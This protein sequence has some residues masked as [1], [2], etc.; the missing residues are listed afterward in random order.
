MKKRIMAVILSLLLLASMSVFADSYPVWENPRQVN[1]ADCKT[2]YMEEGNPFVT[3]YAPWL[4]NFHLLSDYDIEHGVLGGEACQYVCALDISPVN[5]DVMYFG[6][7]TSGVY[8]TTTRGKHW[9]N[10]TGNAAGH[11]VWSIMCDPFDVNTVYVTMRKTGTHRSRDG[12]K[13]WHQLVA[14][15]DQSPGL[16]KSATVASDKSGDIYIAA[17]NGIYKLDY[18][19]EG[20]TKDTLTNLFSANDSVV[21]HITTLSGNSGAKWSDI[22]VSDDGIIYAAGESRGSFKG[23]LYVSEDGGQ[24]WEI[25]GEEKTYTNEITTIA[26]HPETKGKIFAGM[27]RTNIETGEKSGFGLYVSQDYGKTWEYVCNYEVSTGVRVFYELKFGP[28]E[29]HD[30]KV[31]TP[32]VYPLYLCINPTNYPHRV[33]YDEGKTGFSSEEN[34]LYKYSDKLGYGSSRTG[35]DSAH[36]WGYSAFAVDMNE[37]GRVIVPVTG[38]YEYDKFDDNGSIKESKLTRINAGFSG[39]AI[40]D[41]A[42]DKN[43]KM[44]LN[45]ID[46]GLWI[47]DKMS[48]IYDGSKYP[49]FRANI[50]DYFVHS[51]FQPDSTEHIVSYIGSSNGSGEYSGI[52][53]SYDGG[54]TFKPM[55][56]D[57]KLLSSAPKDDSAWAEFG[58]AQVLCY[59]DTNKNTIYSSYHNSYDNGIKWSKNKYYIAAVSP[60]NT[61]RQL[62]FEKVSEKTIALYLTEN[63]GTSWEKVMTL[64]IGNVNDIKFDRNDDNYVWYTTDKDFLKLNLETRTAESLS[65]KFKYPAFTEFEINP[66]NPNHMLVASSPGTIPERMKY[67]FKVAESL[68]GGNTWHTVP[69]FWGSS[70]NRFIFSKTTNEVFVGTMGGLMIY[71]YEKF[72]YYTALVLTYGS[73]VLRMTVPRIDG[74]GNNVNNGAYVIAPEDVFKPFGKK[75]TGWEI[76]G[77]VYEIGQMIPILEQN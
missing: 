28:K 49:T 51:V 17:G 10:V 54:V 8:K 41:I 68:D 37:P 55:N 62:G 21:G 44:F 18:T 12:G 66:K 73:K 71:D 25:R 30:G 60:K 1:E 23:G 24:T 36:G 75:L 39:A 20:R 50:D 74:N 19:D 70:L 63:A 27:S 40:M 65:S 47:Q 61:K 56:N 69:G 42:F 64:P 5:T 14:D 9:Y 22:K 3:H 13:T 35:F 57:A 38:L 15:L 33:S 59:D 32:E 43:N 58:N 52:R 77:K 72:N 48:D 31:A 53:Q 6:T 7:N 16:T 76:G 26:L 67:D 11:D 4:R 46:S 29:N 2:P 45:V 34:Q